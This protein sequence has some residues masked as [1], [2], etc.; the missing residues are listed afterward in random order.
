MIEVPDDTILI[1]IKDRHEIPLIY[2]SIGR[3]EAIICELIE[4]GRN[5]E[6]QSKFFYDFWFFDLQNPENEIEE[7]KIA[8]K[9][10]EDICSLYDFK[11]RLWQLLI[12]VGLANN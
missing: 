4:H 5:V 11:I 12:Q 7:N 6:E 9:C 2:E 1:T 10:A 8:R 3:D